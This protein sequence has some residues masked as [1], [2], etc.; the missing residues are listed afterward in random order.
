KACARC[1]PTRTSSRGGST[2][3]SRACRD[4]RCWS[5]SPSR[6]VLTRQEEPSMLELE[7]VT[8]RFPGGSVAVDDL[9]LRARDRAITVLVGPS[10]CGKTTTLRMINRMVEPTSGTVTI[11]GRDVQTMDP[12]QLRR[13]IG[14]VIQHGGL[15]PHHT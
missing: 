12:A 1:S 2:P 15:F 13:G 7:G 6:L 11:D 3:T 14:Y 8:K 4:Q 10:G 5:C 9:S